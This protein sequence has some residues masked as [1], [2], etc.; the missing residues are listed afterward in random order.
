M[1]GLRLDFGASHIP[2]AALSGDWRGGVH[3]G[4][5]LARRVGPLGILE[6]GSWRVNRLRMIIL[7]S[8]G[9]FG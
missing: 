4:L 7:S 1:D 5:I 3:G 6:A 9:Q 2:N 8:H